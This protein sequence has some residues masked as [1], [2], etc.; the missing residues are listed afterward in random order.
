[1]HHFF[2]N[3]VE[4][5]VHPID[6]SNS[7]T[8]S[9][10]LDVGLPLES[11]VEGGISHFLEH[12]CFRGTQRRSAYEITKEVDS[13]GG[14]VNAYTTKEFTCYYITVLPESILEGLDILM[15]IVFHSQHADK[16][17]ELEKSIINEEINM[18]EDTPDDK[19]LDLLSSEL[20][21]GAY[22]GKPILGTAS[23]IGQFSNQ[24]LMNYYLNYR[25]AKN[26]KCVVAGAVTELSNLKH[27]LQLAFDQVEFTD[28][29]NELPR[30]DA[31]SFEKRQAHVYKDLEQM[32]LC[33]GY[34]GL[35]YTHA[36]RYALT[37]LTTLLGGSMSSRLF[38]SVRERLGLAYSIYCTSQNYR[39]T[40]AI[41]IYAGT[42]TA[43]YRKA[44]DCI[45]KEIDQLRDGI[46]DDE[47]ERTKRQLKGN[48][49]IH[50]EGSS[51]WANWLGRQLIYKTGLSTLIQLQD[52]LNQITKDDVI[53]LSKSM[54]SDSVQA[55]V[56]LGN[57][58]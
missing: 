4:T 31:M 27:Q 10:F 12:M 48:M 39:D 22:L 7:V 17:I 58:K 26:I 2:I 52:R 51:A 24:V 45:E 11:S 3:D 42:A 19:I 16:N 40:G 46:T 33:Y 43:Q 57:A 6:S 41:V 21:N 36:D 18:Y 47:F 23:S 1:M 28:S 53:R 35:K 8:L 56:S 25:V 30:L 14:Q 49:I 15:D 20:F 38:Q 34:P 5:V 32:H 29:S 50:L 37:L 54:F 55:K 9:I 44:Q 13:L